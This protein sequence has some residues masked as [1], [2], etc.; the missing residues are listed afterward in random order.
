MSPLAIQVPGAA[1]YFFTQRRGDAEEGRTDFFMNNGNS[2][3]SISAERL[4]WISGQIVDAAVKVHSAIGPGLIEAV[5]ETVLCSELTQRGLSVERQKRISFMYQG[6][7]F[8]NVG[9]A[10]MIVEDAVIV[11][12]K[13]AA[14]LAAIH[15]KQLLTYLRLLDHRLGLVL[16]FGAPLMKDGIHRVVNKM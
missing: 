1:V 12:V 13:S 7:L 8:E 3:N 15:H 11:E 10:D 2:N 9:R 5:Y 16:N 6:T 4:N 14:V